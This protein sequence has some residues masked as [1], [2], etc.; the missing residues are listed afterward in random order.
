VTIFAWPTM[1]AA[2]LASL[3]EFVEALTIVLAVGAVRGWRAAWTGA[4]AAALL[5]AVLVG[6]FGPSLT[7]LNTA[8]F[9]LIIGTLLLLFGLRWLQKAILRASGHIA[10]HDE[11]KIYA[12]QT[13]ALS[14]RDADTKGG[15]D[16]GGALTAFNGVLIEGLE[17]IFIVLAVGAA[18]G[19][20]H[21]VPA[22][23]G[24]S[25]AAVI[26]VFLGIIAQKPL[27]QIPENALKLVVGV[28]V[29]AFGTFWTGEGLGLVW[30]GGDWSTVGLSLAWLA[31]AGI[32][33][34]MTRQGAKGRA[35]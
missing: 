11:T 14:E 10:L 18:G 26:V 34:A 3:V 30:P 21:L 12:R 20:A 9:K 33:Y 8:I 22:M 32:G 2:F 24:A 15:L 31:V 25:A 4:I 27:S 6:V 1:L 28:L 17:V 16:I 5:L 29:S 13:A 35:G 23:I 7:H 19:S